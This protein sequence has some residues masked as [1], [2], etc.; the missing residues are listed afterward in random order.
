[1][2]EKIMEFLPDLQ[3]LMDKL[4]GACRIAALIGPV[5]LLILGLLYMFR[6]P[7]EANHLVGFRC[8]WGMG[9]VE[10][11]Q[12]TQRLAGGA[13]TGMGLALS[14]IALVSGLKFKEL[15][16]DE[17]LRQTLRIIGWQAIMVLVSIIV[18]NIILIVLFDHRGA[19]RRDNK[20]PE[21]TG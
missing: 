7:E 20:T 15:A 6:A 13:W 11:W 14:G 9:S 16:Y 8:W 1:M 19:R 18:I 5:A 12:F 17:M 2:T 21:K 4:P 10:S 3:S